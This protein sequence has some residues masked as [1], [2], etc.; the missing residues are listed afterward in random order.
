MINDWLCQLRS[1]RVFDLAQ[2]YFLGM[3]HHPSHPPFLFSMVKRHGDFIGPKGGSSATDAI[4]M[5]SHVGTHIDALNHFS[6]AGMLH[7]GEPAG[8]IQ[9]WE[10][11][12]QKHAIDGVP[13]ILR[14]GVLL[15]IAG[16]R[17]APLPED[18]EITPEDLERAAGGLQIGPGD[19]V[20]LRTGWAQYFQDARKFISEVRGP[21][22]AIRGAKWLSARGIYAA[23]S[24][25]VAFE[26]VPDPAMPVHEHLLVQCGIHIIEC[27]NLEELAAA[28]IREF[29]FVAL[30][31]KIRG[32]TASPIRPVA[33]CPP[34]STSSLEP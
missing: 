6:S 11:G 3:P 12:L 14:R 17:G 33:L 2:P 24:D 18:H 10:R 25:T 5:G 8:P 4:A 15:D 21:G 19:V 16:L 20:L 9:S 1:A 22:P 23:G 7:G 27:L 30:P 26:R 28:A 34:G 29:L 31:L 32:A 13:P